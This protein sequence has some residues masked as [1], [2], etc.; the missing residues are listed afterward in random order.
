MNRCEGEKR[1]HMKVFVDRIRQEILKWWDLLL[2]SDEEREQF[3]AFTSECY[4]EDLLQLHE[5]EL[6]SLKNTYEKNK[7]VIFVNI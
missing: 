5:M 3:G 6:E 1:R 7:F 2:K 4:N